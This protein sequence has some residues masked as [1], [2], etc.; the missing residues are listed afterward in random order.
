MISYLEV[1][2]P[3]LYKWLLP[4]RLTPTTTTPWPVEVGEW[5]PD[6]TPVLC[7]SGWH[8]VEERD[9]LAHL[10]KALG[11][12]LWEVEARGVVVVGDDKS[13]ATSLRLVRL[14][15]TTTAKNLRLFACDVAEDALSTVEVPDPR[16]VAVI[17]VARRFARGEATTEELDAAWAAAWIAE[18]AA[19]RAA[20]W[21]AA[22]ASAWAAESAAAWAAERASAWAAER[23][24]ES[25][26]AGATD[27]AAACAAA[28]DQYSNWLVVRL[29]S[30]Y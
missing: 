21:T 23:A 27:I 16:S 20:A 10:P 30:G 25:A 8:F 24:A 1:T 12:E 6:A 15:G 13:C 9:V 2:R 17:E 28:K 11:A 5:T 29:E 18:C 14:V 19:E 4:G 22:R 26:A 7:R 3:T